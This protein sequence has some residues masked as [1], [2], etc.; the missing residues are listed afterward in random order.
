MPSPANK[1]PQEMT[2]RE[3]ERALAP[4]DASKLP[5]APS[6]DDPKQPAKPVS[7]SVAWLNWCIVLVRD[8]VVIVSVVLI[9]RTCV[10]S[11]FQIY[12]ESMFDSYQDGELILLDH[13]SYFGTKNFGRSLERG[14]LG[15]VATLTARV[16]H[17]T[18]GWMDL[19]IGDP[20]RGDVVVFRP[21]AGDGKD[22]YIKRV[23]GEPGDTV[24]I[25]K[26]RVFVKKAGAAEFI[27]LEE[28]YL[29]PAN[30]EGTQVPGAQDTFKVPSGKYFVMGDNR[31]WSSDS[32]AC[33]RAPFEGCPSEASHY[34]DRS[35]VLGKVLVSFGKLSCAKNGFL[36]D[37]LKG[38]SRGKLSCASQKTALFEGARWLSTPRIWIYPEL[39]PTRQ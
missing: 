5:V 26:G 2:I 20:K 22:Y 31:Q 21:H 25:D 32:R 28:T 1:S 7:K 34:V 14:D 9:I 38:V 15:P 16:L 29:T 12:G 23:I 10:A 6:A 17:W 3:I 35:D 13:A 8:V 4:E 11:P 19:K 36:D 30:F 33:F 24:K 37:V 27:R 18:V 39:T